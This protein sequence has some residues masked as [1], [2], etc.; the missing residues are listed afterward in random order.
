MDLNST[1]VELKERDTFTLTA[2]VTPSDAT[3]K[4]VIFRTSNAK[5]ATVGEKT[6]IIKG[7]KAGK[8]IITAISGNKTKTCQVTVKAKPNASNK[9]K[10]S[11]TSNTTKIQIAKGDTIELENSKVKYKTTMKDGDIVKFNKDDKQYIKT[12]NAIGLGTVTIPITTNEANNSNKTLIVIVVPINKIINYSVQKYKPILEDYRVYNPRGNFQNFAITNVGKSNQK[13]YVT[14]QVDSVV[15]IHNVYDLSKKYISNYT[16][17]GQ[18]FDIDQNGKFLLL[19]KK[20]GEN[21]NKIT[22]YKSFSAEAPSI[23]L[24]PGLEFTIDYE[25]SF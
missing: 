8:A 19:A 14:T 12:I 23:S 6:G 3:N 17:H 2:T 16:S 11:L 22:V 15:T 20:T 1:S 13:I 9:H 4:T 7:I 25:N 10:L 21:S 24:L 18:G 5:I